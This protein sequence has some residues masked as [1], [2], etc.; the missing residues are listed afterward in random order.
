MVCHRH[1]FPPSKLLQDLSNVSSPDRSHERRA[2]KSKSGQQSK[3]CSRRRSAATKL[4][5]TFDLCLPEE[6][7]LLPHFDG[8]ELVQKKHRLRDELE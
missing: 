5:S 3:V 2:R 7:Q 1:Q 4:V 6:W 8:E